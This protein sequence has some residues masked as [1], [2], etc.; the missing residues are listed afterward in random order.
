MITHISLIVLIVCSLAYLVVKRKNT[1]LE[2]IKEACSDPSADSFGQND[3]NQFEIDEYIANAE[4]E[5]K[6]RLEAIKY[7]MFLSKKEWEEAYRRY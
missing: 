5:K 4:R 3:P 2:M 6:K 7:K 1:E